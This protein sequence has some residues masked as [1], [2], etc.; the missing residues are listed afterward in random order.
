[1]GSL[2]PILTLDHPDPT[3]L[4]IHLL[5]VIA[6]VVVPPPPRDALPEL[7]Y[8]LCF[9][10]IPTD[11]GSVKEEGR[12]DVVPHIVSLL[13]GTDVPRLMLEDRVTFPSPDQSMQ[14]VEHVF[15]PQ[16]LLCLAAVVEIDPDY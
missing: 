10:D 6:A 3:I 9:V 4:A 12:M 15:H 14:I 1:M 11:V 16:T 5:V 13:Y 2:A 8:Q 7:S